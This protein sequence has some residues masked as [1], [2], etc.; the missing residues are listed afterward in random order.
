[1]YQH[2]ISYLINNLIKLYTKTVNTYSNNINKYNFNHFLIKQVE[3]IL[4][5]P[6]NNNN[7]HRFIII[8]ILI[9]KLFNNK[10]IFITDKRTLSKSIKIGCILNLHNELLINLLYLTTLHSIPKFN[11]N[12]IILNLYKSEI[13]SYELKKI[14]SHLIFNLDKD[15]NIYYDYLG[16]FDY[17]FNI[18]F[19]TQIKSILHNRLLLNVLGYYFFNT[20]I[21]INNK[22]FE[23]TWNDILLNELENNEIEEDY[24]EEN[25][26]NTD[27]FIED[28][29][30]IIG[31]NDDEIMEYSDLI[32]NNIIINYKDINL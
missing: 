18:I 32:I 17:S 24:I 20:Y 26:N 7:I 29:Y 31:Y 22:L 4:I 12:N 8:L 6:S 11:N 9:E 30:N 19:K 16:E 14:I 13:V 21:L 25:I 10:V 1:M 27:D 28:E 15:I 3:I 23:Y 2:K 5:I